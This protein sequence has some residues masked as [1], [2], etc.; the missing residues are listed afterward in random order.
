MKIITLKDKEAYKISDD[1][2]LKI[3]EFAIQCKRFT[4]SQIVELVKE[5]FSSS[6]SEIPNEVVKNWIVE[7]QCFSPLLKNDLNIE[8]RFIIRLALSYLRNNVEDLPVDLYKTINYGDIQDLI[9]IL[10]PN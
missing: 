10:F 1:L 6:L 5:G 4:T 9:K 7:I 2:E 8:Q 3:I